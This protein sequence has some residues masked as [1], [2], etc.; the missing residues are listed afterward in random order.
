MIFRRNDSLRWGYKFRG[1]P[2][3]QL[4][5]VLVGTIFIG[6]LQDFVVEG[7]FDVKDLS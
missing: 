2:I 5:K 4:G 7:A 1:V 3:R 6:G